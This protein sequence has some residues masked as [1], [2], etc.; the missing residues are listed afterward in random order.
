MQQFERGKRERR[1]RGD[2]GPR[3]EA[4][5][6]RGAAIDGE[7]GYGRPPAAEAAPPVRRP[8]AEAPLRR[9]RRGRGDARG[10]L[11]AVQYNNRALE[12]GKAP[13]KNARARAQTGDACRGCGPTPSAKGRSQ[14]AEGPPLTLGRGWALG[15]C[16]RGVPWRW[17]QVLAAIPSW[18]WALHPGRGNRGRWCCWW[19]A[20]GGLAFRAS[21]PACC[22]LV[23][24]VLRCCPVAGAAAVGP[25]SNAGR[26]RPLRITISMTTW[27]CG[28]C[29]RLEAGPFQSWHRGR[30]DP[31]FLAR[32]AFSPG[33]P[34][35]A[36]GSFGRPCHRTVGSKAGFMG[37]RGEEADPARFEILDQGTEQRIGMP[38]RR[39]WPGVL[40]LWLCCNS[41]AVRRDWAGGGRLDAP[42]KA[43]SRRGYFVTTSD[44]PGPKKPGPSVR[45]GKA[46]VRGSR[47]GEHARRPRPVGR[48]AILCRSRRW[49]TPPRKSA[50]P[51]GNAPIDPAMALARSGRPAAP[52]GF[53]PREADQVIV[54]LTLE[55]RWALAGL[56]IDF[57]RA[58][59]EARRRESISK[60]ALRRAYG[61]TPARES[62]NRGLAVLR[63]RAELFRLLL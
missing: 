26:S 20:A 21:L 45:I 29:L 40:G 23:F 41:G 18:L 22:C 55:G 50:C 36:A 56:W 14:N 42:G 58:P 48:G 54:S 9:P 10:G 13:G 32:T 47:K 63:N 37:G 5:A 52:P 61:A 19:A 51:R 16:R 60:A 25:G 39:G 33:E 43:G 31:P 53:R 30:K 2:A 49:A 34:C 6:P 1:R 62:K 15:R 38:S 17:A 12:Q 11:E 59:A 7:I 27:T 3:A 24:A 46:P 35:R 4:R 28:L 44:R 57:P 8:D